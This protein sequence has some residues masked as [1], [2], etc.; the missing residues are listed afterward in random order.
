[1]MMTVAT[2]L[3]DSLGSL[4]HTPHIPPNYDV[5]DV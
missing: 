4:L 5:P 3:I 2:G 1:M